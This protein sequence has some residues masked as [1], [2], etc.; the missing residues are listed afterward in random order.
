MSW[1]KYHTE[2]EKLAIEA[3]EAIR[4]GDAARAKRLFAC[5][6]TSETKALDA[7]DPAKVRTYGVTAVSAVALW[8]KA[9]ELDEAEGL[10]Y[11]ALANGLPA[12]AKDQLQQLLQT[13]WNE[14]AWIK[15]P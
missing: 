11:R 6:A 14:A 2:S 7:L 5:A 8:Y 12:F 3:H 4:F 13:I 10:A 9:K 1:T 15:K